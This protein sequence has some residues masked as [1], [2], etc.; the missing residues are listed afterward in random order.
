MN[1][2]TFCFDLIDDD[3]DDH[4]HYVDDDENTAIFS[5][6]KSHFTQVV[7]QFKRDAHENTYIVK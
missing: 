6:L 1:R 3:G 7:Y 4:L 5:C 2:G